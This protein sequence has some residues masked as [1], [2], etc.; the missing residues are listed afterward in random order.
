[1]DQ[2]DDP[3]ELERKIEQ[4]SRIASRVTDQTTVERL[5][6][7]IEDLKQ[8]LRQRLEARRT[9]QAI[10]ARAQEIWEQNGRPSDRDL[11]FWLQAE[12]EINERM[13]K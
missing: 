7:W 6:A 4:A 9:R 8:K 2:S 13:R 3:R 11:D 10:S 12:S 1:M 5:R